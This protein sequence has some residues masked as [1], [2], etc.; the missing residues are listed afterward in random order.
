M[1][2][3]K[4][5]DIELKEA[6]DDDGDFLPGRNVLCYTINEII[7]KIEGTYN[8]DDRKFFYVPFLKTNDVLLDEKY[9]PVLSNV[10]ELTELS[11]AA[12]IEAFFKAEKKPLVTRI[13]DILDGED[14][15]GS[16]ELI[17]NYLEAHPEDDSDLVL[18][19]EKIKGGKE[20][21]HNN[22]CMYT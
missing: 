17:I 12:R 11:A 1:N 18:L 14:D 13:A 20:F 22:I 7:Q 19:A 6:T 3:L 4:A 2:D 16:A 15:Y 9:L 10:E 21:P 8:E 5:A